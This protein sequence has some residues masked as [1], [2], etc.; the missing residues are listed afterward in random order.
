MTAQGQSEFVSVGESALAYLNQQFPLDLWII[1]RVG[2]DDYIVL[3]SS[4]D[5]P[6]LQPCITYN[7]HD[8]IF[9]RMPHS[10]GT[11][12]VQDVEDVPLYRE[13]PMVN[14]LNIRG[15][16]SAPIWVNG[17]LFGSLCGIQSKPLA[18]YM[19][20]SGPQINQLV[21]QIATALT[22]DLALWEAQREQE[23]ALARTYL[24][25]VT[26]IP[27]W[28]GWDV[29]LDA[30]NQRCKT[31]GNKGV[32][33]SVDLADLKGINQKLGREAGD[34]VLK[35][36]AEIIRSLIRQQDMVAR[37]GNDEFGVLCIEYPHT[38]EAAL[39]QCI[40]S[41]L[42]QAG[43]EVD[44]GHAVSLPHKGL[45]DAWEVAEHTMYKARKLRAFNN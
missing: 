34:G 13:A 38:D 39:S 6:H 30:E 40:F 37:V 26:Q 3:Q 44:V 15:V 18:D 5:S 19:L 7:L 1:A 29:I 20:D 17:Q 22:H 8:S 45:R 36:T 10:P 16:L 43:I 21:D 33:I 23:R 4:Q 2:G 9:S 24:D 27:D 14:N 42:N 31:F 41:A 11:K 28:R 32:V 35:Q 12:I 25:P